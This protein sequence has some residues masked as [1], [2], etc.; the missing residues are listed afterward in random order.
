[1]PGK[2]AQPL[3]RT[4]TGGRLWRALR[5]GGPPE[6]SSLAAGEGAPNGRRLRRIALYS[7]SILLVA[8]IA[9]GDSHGEET[10]PATEDDGDAS[11]I[12]AVLEEN[13]V[14]LQQFGDYLAQSYL[15]DAREELEKA[16]TK[17]REA[18]SG[19]GSSWDRSSAAGAARSAAE[20]AKTYA[21]LARDNAA[22]Y[23]SAYTRD[24]V[25]QVTAV[26]ELAARYA[27]VAEDGIR[28]EE[29]RSDA[30]VFADE[31]ERWAAK[32][33]EMLKVAEEAARSAEQDSDAAIE[34]DIALGAA[35]HAALA[36][37]GYILLIR[38]T[39]ATT[40]ADQ[41]QAARE[42]L[43]RAQRAA[44]RAKEVDLRAGQ[45]ERELYPIVT[46]PLKINN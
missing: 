3:T 35:R 32:A 45:I 39:F 18:T 2:N 16:K 23:P 38:N 33:E 1:M 43:Q 22:L 21:D 5:I 15:D 8:A 31:S 30:E 4:L 36:S 9:W 13:E 7:L 37:Q 10:E 24:I 28:A 19:A 14:D 44:A 11:D 6:K 46:I 40:E 41:L 27:Q 26:A 25:R 29:S 42:A 12:H 20:W 17:A 34:A